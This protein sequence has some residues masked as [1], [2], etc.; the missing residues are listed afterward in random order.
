MR[1]L[2]TSRNDIFAKEFLPYLGTGLFD[3]LNKLQSS[4]HS[5]QLKDLFIE[6]VITSPVRMTPLTT[7]IRHF[8]KPLLLA[9][10]PSDTVR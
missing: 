1:S 9:I 2:V 10:E 8:M 5:Q 6:L 3:N 4:A 7:C